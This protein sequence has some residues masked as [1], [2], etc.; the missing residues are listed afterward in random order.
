L[1]ERWPDQDGE[2]CERFDPRVQCR[3]VCHEGAIRLARI[4]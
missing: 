1:P 2:A 4:A 3:W